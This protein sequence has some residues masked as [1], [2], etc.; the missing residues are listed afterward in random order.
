MPPSDGSID[1]APFPIVGST[2]CF[3]IASD[4][5]MTDTGRAR[6]APD[7]PHSSGISVLTSRPKFISILHDADDQGLG[8]E[9]AE[10][11]CAKNMRLSEIALRYTYCAIRMAMVLE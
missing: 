8:N 11:E 5:T 3:G 9:N 2:D 4:P 1:M 10:H 7:A 6:R